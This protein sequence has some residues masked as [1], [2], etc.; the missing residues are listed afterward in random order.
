[1]YKSLTWLKTA[2]QTVMAKSQIKMKPTMTMHIQAQVH[3]G[4]LEMIGLCQITE[5]YFKPPV[6]FAQ[7]KCSRMTEWLVWPQRLTCHC[8]ANISSNVVGSMSGVKTPPMLNSMMYGNTNTSMPGSPHAASSLLNPNFFP[9]QIDFSCQG[10]EAL[11]Y[12]SFVMSI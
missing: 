1:M 10:I 9:P 7:L 6:S 12:G 4:K 3:P 2:I 11:L 8:R 5:D